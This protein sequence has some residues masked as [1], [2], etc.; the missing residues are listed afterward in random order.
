[1]ITTHRRCL[2]SDP[3]PTTFRITSTLGYRLCGALILRPVYWGPYIGALILPI[4]IFDA[5]A[6]TLRLQDTYILEVFTDALLASFQRCYQDRLQNIYIRE[7]TFTRESITD[8]VIHRR[9]RWYRHV[10]RM[11]SDNIIRQISSDTG[12]PLLTAERLR[13]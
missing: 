4:A 8:V 5:E 12:L 2:T 11:Q 1:M 10:C 7:D 3:L 6:W 13:T 9:L